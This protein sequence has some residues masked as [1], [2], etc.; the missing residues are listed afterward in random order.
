MEKR[1]RCEDIVR[2]VPKKLMQQG[3]DLCKRN[4]TDFLSEAQLTI[5]K[6]KLNHACISVEFAIEELGKILVLRDAMK[7]VADPVFINGKE[8]CSH[9]RKSEKAWAVL[10][11]N[12]R[13]IFEGDFEEEDFDHRDFLT[14]T[15]ASHETRLD[16]A[17]VD[18]YDGDWYL[19]RDIDKERLVNLIKHI[20]E[21]LKTV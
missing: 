18:Y 16:C 14:N 4:I 7:S 13:T 1:K 5:T 10:D 9:T 17:F 2:S 19:G 12:F 6:G 11:S 3:I 21:T 8:F 15:T 20:E